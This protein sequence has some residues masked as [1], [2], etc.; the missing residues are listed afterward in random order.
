MIMTV[1]LARG[2]LRLAQQ[3]VITKQLAALQNLGG[4]DVLCTDKTGTLT[5][6]HIRLVSHLDISGQDN[7]QVLTLA[8]LNSH[9][10]TG[11]RSPLDTAIL[12]HGA[13]DV[14][15]WRKI[16]EVPFDFERRRV[17][18]LL[19]DGHDRRLV[20]K[21]SPEDILRLSTHYVID[22][23]QP[24]PLDEAA[25]ARAQALYQQLSQQGLR[26][27]GVA[28]DRCRRRTSMPG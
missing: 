13:V 19:D 7:P 6:A 5:E 3:K 22:D 20:I 1:T 9:F 25:L 11:L 23:E 4:M 14:S 18:V 8:Y 28:G 21:G 12:E 2:A 10:E 27:L 24:M 17:S 16:D 26:C 15:T